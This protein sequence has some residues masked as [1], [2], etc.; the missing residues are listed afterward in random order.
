MTLGTPAQAALIEALRS[1]L[2]GDARVHSAWLSGSFGRGKA[3]AWSDV[4]ILVVVDAEDLEPSVAEYGGMRNPVGETVFLRVLFSRVVTAVTPDWRRYDLLF[5]TPQ[6]FRSRDPAAILPLIPGDTPRPRPKPASTA[7]LDGRAGRLPDLFSEF[8]RVLGLLSVAVG[9]HEWLMGQE[10]FR[11]LRQL[12]IDLMLELNGSGA[13]EH[14]GVKRLN[15]RLTDAQRV[16]LEALIGPGAD[17]ASLIAANTGIARLFLPLAR[18]A[19]RDF[20][21]AWPAAFEAATLRHLQAELDLDP[22]EISG[23]DNG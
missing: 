17:A 21:T 8:L 23:Q 10:G 19:A 16:A 3:D 15:E 18:A 2:A 12:T 22:R 7:W 9:R 20:G 14:G 13:P 11:L 4:D 5:L 1:V 6:E